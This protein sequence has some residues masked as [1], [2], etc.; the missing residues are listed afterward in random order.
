MA[1]YTNVSEGDSCG[2]DLMCNSA[3][4]CVECIDNKDCPGF[5]NNCV[6]DVCV[7]LCKDGVKSGNETDIDCGGSCPDCADGK[8]CKTDGDCVN[9]CNGGICGQ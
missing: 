7:E 6:N 5:T 4:K 8:M 2:G 1:V 9:D 3:G